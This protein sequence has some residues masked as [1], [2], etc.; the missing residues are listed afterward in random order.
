MVC[1]AIV[2]EHFVVGVLL[3]FMQSSAAAY[4]CLA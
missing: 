2:Q 1:A 3:R 4:G